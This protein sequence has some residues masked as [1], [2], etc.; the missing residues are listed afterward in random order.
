VWSQVS[1]M[2]EE[3]N[4]EQL[5]ALFLLLVFL[6]LEKESKN[7]LEAP[8]IPGFTCCG[9]ISLGF[10]QLNCFLEKRLPGEAGSLWLGQVILRAW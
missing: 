5:R 3:M 2:L 6:S 9:T 10:M 7:Q 8:Y 1:I 4:L